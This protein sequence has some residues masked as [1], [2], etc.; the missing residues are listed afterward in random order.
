MVIKTPL[1]S[2]D[3]MREKEGRYSLDQEIGYQHICC[4]YK[5]C[6]D[7]NFANTQYPKKDFTCPIAIKSVENRGKQFS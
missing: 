5:S 3:P 2:T 1:S 7:N 4:I 6:Q